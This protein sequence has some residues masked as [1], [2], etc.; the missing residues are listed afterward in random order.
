LDHV[1]H[2]GQNSSK[3]LETMTHLRWEWEGVVVR[4]LRVG[5]ISYRDHPTKE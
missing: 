3:E 1:Q 4:G 2:L 5:F